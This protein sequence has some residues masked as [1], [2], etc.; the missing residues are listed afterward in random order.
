ME[1]NGIDFHH[2]REAGETVVEVKE[3]RCSDA[4]GNS[5]IIKNEFYLT[6]ALLCDGQQAPS[7]PSTYTR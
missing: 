3:A 2:K 1:E 4:A 7:I 5:L 6:L